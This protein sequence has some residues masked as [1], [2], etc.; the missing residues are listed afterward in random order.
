MIAK[1]RGKAKNA[2]TLGFEAGDWLYGSLINN[3][4]FFEDGTPACSILDTNYIADGCWEDLA[5]WMDDFEVDPA[6]VGQ[7][8]GKKDKKGIDVYEGDVFDVADRYVEVYWNEHLAM[9]DT[10]FKAFNGKGGKWFVGGL[11]SC[12]WEQYAEV[13][14]NI[15]EEKI[16]ALHMVTLDGIKVIVGINKVSHIKATPQGDDYLI[17]VHTLSGDSYQTMLA[18]LDDIPEEL[19]K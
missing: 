17:R 5:D 4:F 19:L 9:W 10:K 12:D 2:S 7:W 1:F 11:K 16:L 13:V 18:D 15:H 6:T 8:T 3:A 14:G